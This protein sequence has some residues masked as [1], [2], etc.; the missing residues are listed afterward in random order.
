MDVTLVS[1][2]FKFDSIVEF[3]SSFTRFPCL[4]NCVVTLTYAHP[5][6]DPLV[7]LFHHFHCH[8]FLFVPLFCK[9][10]SQCS[11]FLCSVQ[12]CPT[13]FVFF[14]SR[15]AAVVASRVLQSSDSMTWVID[16][17]PEPQDVYWSSLWLP[18]GTL[19]IR[20]ILAFVAT[21]F[22]VFVFMGPVT[23][24][25]GLTQVEN[26]EKYSVTLKRLLSK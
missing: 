9:A 15:Y 11:L 7:S 18:Y 16:P 24:V 26:L 5:K 21:L 8:I 10:I 25:Q 4:M 6:S 2:Q 1:H 23:F 19:W 20:K 14:K 22:I 17:A 12:E 13:A 3:H